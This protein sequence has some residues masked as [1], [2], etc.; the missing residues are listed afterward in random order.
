MMDARWG[1]TSL[2]NGSVEI[3]SRKVQW[4]CHQ[5]RNRY[6]ILP[7]HSPD[8]N[9]L[10]FRFWAA[11]RNE[12][13]RKKP[14]SIDSLIQCVR[15]IAESYD[16]DTIRRVSHNVLKRAGLCLHANGSHFQHLL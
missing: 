1:S 14:E 15:R 6:I 2:Y 3:S 8:L 16:E 10:D 13:Y 5:P 4:S 12:V 11:A 7:A 9:P